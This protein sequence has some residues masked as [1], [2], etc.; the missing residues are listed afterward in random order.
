VSLRNFSLLVIPTG[1]GR[2]VRAAWT[3]PCCEA[4][5]CLVWRVREESAVPVLV[6]KLQA[7]SADP[8]AV[9]IVDIIAPLGPPPPLYVVDDSCDVCERALPEA[10]QVRSDFSGALERRR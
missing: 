1:A 10:L 6:A 8:A 5:H 3:A 7:A 2:F 4:L 9:H